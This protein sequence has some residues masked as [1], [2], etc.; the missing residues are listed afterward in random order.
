MYNRPRI[1]LDGVWEFSI[2]GG[3][4]ERRTVPGSYP[5]VGDSVYRR[6]VKISTPAPDRRLRLCFEGIA[7]EGDLFFNGT[8]LGTML[9]YSFYAYDITDLIKGEEDNEIRL[10]LKD[11]NAVFGPSE[12]WKSFSGI[13]RSVFLEESPKLCLDDVFFTYTFTE[14]YGQ[15]DCNL[16]IALTDEANDLTISASISRQGILCCQTSSVSAARKDLKLTVTKPSLWSPEEPSLYELEVLLCKDGIVID[17]YTCNVGFKDLVVKGSKFLLNGKDLFIT[18]ICRHDL[19]NEVVGF[20]QTDDMIETDLQMM[21]N[22]GVNYVRLVHYPH[23]RRVVEACDRIGLLCS[24]EPGLWWSDLSNKEITTR[25]LKVLE[26]VIYRDRNH[27]SIAFWLSFNECIFN[28]EF[29]HDAVTTARRCDPSRLISGA[30]CND[31]YETKELF[32]KYDVDFYTMHPYG[33]APEHVNG[34]TL[35]QCCRVLSGKPLIFTEWGGFFVHENPHL[36][37][38]FCEVMRRL[39][40]NQEP[41]PVLAGMS[42]WQWQDIPEAQRGMPACY[43]GILIEGLVSMDREPKT[44]FYTYMHFLEQLK[45][46]AVKRVP[47]FTPVG[48]GSPDQSYTPI[49]LPKP[50]KDVWDQAIAASLPMPG[51]HHKKNRRITVGPALPDPVPQLGALIT[52]LPAGRPAVISAD[53]GKLIVPV[54][55]SA[56][57]LW[58]IGQATLGKGYPTN[59]I[60]G[61]E[62]G[63][64]IIHYADGTTQALPLRD[65][66]ESATVFGLIGPTAFDPRAARTSRAFT[67]DYN[68]NWEVYHTGMLRLSCE[69]KPIDSVEISVTDPEYFLLLYGITAED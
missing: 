25:A 11:L 30:N 8:K 7:Y 29:L 16:A 46:P 39:H 10:D 50:E 5:C 28:E 43:E 27:V 13:I 51:Y 36:F 23:D 9:P 32:D 54:H 67:I 4:V 2:P 47:V 17:S 41:D 21:K 22:M 19:W 55:R 53:S 15:A 62:Y 14:C 56:S 24:E 26:N 48:G 38:E 33:T 59:G 52:D 61:T 60:R 35:E 58:F 37:E 12:G 34:G 44:N 6:T 69:K 31:I 57:A 64:Y 1:S 49:P 40:N 63:A 3:I 45:R 66:E 18:G 65:G 68:R 42:Y 20:T